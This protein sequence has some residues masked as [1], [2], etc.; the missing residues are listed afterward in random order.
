MA[1]GWITL[2]SGDRINVF[3]TMPF[4]LVHLGCLAAFFLKFHWSYL[5]VCLSLYYVRMFFVTGGY[6]RYFSHRSYKTSRWFQ[7]VIALWPRPRR[8]KACCG[9][10]PTIGTITAIRTRK[11]TCIRPL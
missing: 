7:F 5:V 11:K 8:R 9:G 2:K 6:H 10:R 4:Y 1:S 3:R